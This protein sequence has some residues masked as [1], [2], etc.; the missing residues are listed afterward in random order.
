[1]T[2]PTQ[3]PLFEPDTGVGSW[4][5]V[6]PA[7]VPEELHRLAGRLPSSVYLGTSS[8]SFPGWGGLVYDRDASERILASEGLGPYGAHVLFRSVGVDR[9]YYRPLPATV[10]EAYRRQLREVGARLRFVVKAHRDCVSPVRPDGTPSPHYLDADYA[11]REV[12]EPARS[13][14]ADDLGAILFQ[15][16]P[17]RYSS[18]SEVR[19]FLR[20]LWEFLVALPRDVPY[21]VEIRSGPLLNDDY[22]RLLRSV[23]A[24]HSYLSH[25]SLPPLRVQAKILPPASMPFLLVRWMLHRAQRYEEARARYAPFRSVIDPDPR[26]RA[27]IGELVRAFGVR[28][29]CPMYIVVSNKAEGC[30]PLSVRELARSLVL[31]PHG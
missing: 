1:M 18:S 22:L 4:G 27:E 3:Y 14:L 8:W 2:G 11:I 16:S 26:S 9:G 24:S 25:P 29:E 20:S 28:E 10:F 12:I 7:P 13:G 21:A 5:R 23:G 30:A 6:G 19:G 15:F 31:D 17:T